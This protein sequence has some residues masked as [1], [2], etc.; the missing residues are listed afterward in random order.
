MGPKVS[1]AAARAGVAAAALLTLLA[2]AGCGD[3]SFRSGAHTTAAAIAP[4]VAKRLLE[5]DTTVLVVDVR[6]QD[7]WN[8]RY[9]HLPRAR[10]IPL[11]DLERRLGEL[12]PWKDKTIILVCTVGQRSHRAAEI[13]E[14]HGFKD[15]RNLSGGL[16]AWRDAGY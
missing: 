5:S 16:Q 4:D 6:N 9:G 3:V 11:P 14:A 2:M 13:L 1:T 10:Q 12:A 8:D 15:A 7:E